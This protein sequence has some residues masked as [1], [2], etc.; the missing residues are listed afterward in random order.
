[1]KNP[2]QN[3]IRKP[4]KTISG[5]TPVAVML[6]PRG[7]KHGNC[8]YLADGAPRCPVIASFDPTTFDPANMPVEITSDDAGTWS[9]WLYYLYTQEVWTCIR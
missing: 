4:T 7:C 3:E 1:M 6:P 5:I 8:I 9:V 2:A